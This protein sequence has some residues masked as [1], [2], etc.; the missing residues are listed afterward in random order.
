MNDCW[1]CTS[2]SIV[3]FFLRP[4]LAWYAISRELRPITFG[5]SRI[6]QFKEP[7]LLPQP[8]DSTDSEA[9]T[10]EV[11]SMPHA[12]GEKTTTVDI[13]GV[14]STLNNHEISATIQFFEISS[15]KKIFEHKKKVSL[16]SNSS[17]EIAT[18]D[19]TKYNPADLVV[20]VLF[21]NP[22]GKVLRSS[23]DWPQPLKYVDFSKREVSVR[24]EGEFVS[25]KAT[26]PIKAVMLD[27]EGD[28]DSGL[29]WSDNGFDIMPDEGVKV[30][31]KGLRGRKPTVNWYRSDS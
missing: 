2:W 1:P 10:K 25:L 6:T 4:K 22:S 21:I 3:D 9:K 18:F 13:W 11:H 8:P 31:A 7:V 23:A 24:V 16:S 26:K 19:L 30:I 17:T 14:N 28:D 12:Y 27:I 29:E 5:I 20:S 15:G